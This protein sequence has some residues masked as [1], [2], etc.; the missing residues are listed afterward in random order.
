LKDDTGRSVIARQGAE[1]VEAPGLLRVAGW[2]RGRLID[3]SAHD[4]P[5]PRKIP[6]LFQHLAMM[7]PPGDPRA[8]GVEEAK[9]PDLIHDM[10]RAGVKASLVVLHEESDEFFSLAARHPGRLFGLA[11]FDSLSPHLGLERVRTLWNDHRD[12]ILGVRTAMPILRQDP[13]LRDFVPLYE[14]CL[15]QD[16]PVQFHLGGHPAGAVSRPTPFGVLAAS[17]P[18][19]RIVC[20]HPGGPWH[21]DLPGLLRQF[22]NLFVSVEG[23]PGPDAEDDGDSRTYRG[24]LR[25]AG[26]RHVMFGSN[27]LGRN[28]AYLQAVQ[29]A[30]SLPWWQ[31]RNVCWRTAV[32]V[33][34]TRIL[35]DRTAQ[36]GTSPTTR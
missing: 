24:F 7:L 19:L 10:D 27:W 2:D 18:R 31:R 9:L 15:E 22:P 21:P 16:L 3:T 8:Q 13:R 30:Q 4:V 26:S 23:S 6:A 20:I 14:F 25:R 35:G 1:E 12:L 5:L 34:G 11:Y 17:Y 29:R 28:P 33:Y 32:Q 36:M